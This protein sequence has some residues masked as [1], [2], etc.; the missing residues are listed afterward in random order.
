MTTINISMN[1][2]LAAFESYD[3]DS[4]R[5]WPDELEAPCAIDREAATQIEVPVPIK[6]LSEPE[7]AVIT[8]PALHLIPCKSVSTL[9]ILTPIS[10]ALVSDT[11][12]IAPSI[13]L[14]FLGRQCRQGSW[15][16][17]SLTQIRL[18]KQLQ[19]I[20]DGRW[21]S[22]VERAHE[23]LCGKTFEHLTNSEID[24]SLAGR[25]ICRVVHCKYY[26]NDFKTMF[27]L[28]GHLHTKAHIELDTSYTLIATPVIEPSSPELNGYD[29]IAPSESP[30]PVFA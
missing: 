12:G 27:M 17:G 30:S 11:V 2:E 1:E 23:T 13:T 20:E 21:L 14:V 19:A 5:E 22:C 18:G 10:R 28:T 9:R 24:W 8:Q 3:K 6:T 26:G 4:G 29:T 7:T 15:S 25:Y 16:Y